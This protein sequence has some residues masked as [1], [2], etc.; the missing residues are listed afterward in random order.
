MSDDTLPLI[1]IVPEPLPELGEL[2]AAGAP[3][4]VI[5]LERRRDDIEL[6]RRR[7]E[8]ERRKAY[9]QERRDVAM[10]IAQLSELVRG[11]AG[12]LDRLEL[13]LAGVRA[14]LHLTRGEVRVLR[15]EVAGFRGASD[16]LADRI[17]ALEGLVEA[18]RNIDDRLT[19][20]EAKLEEENRGTTPAP[21][22]PDAD[23]TG[24][25]DGAAP[26]T[27]PPSGPPPTRQ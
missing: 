24:S 19:R 25:A 4:W 16:N 13:G 26:E 21:A 2:E 27:E 18:V 7:C 23:S 12:R 6:E 14:D 15:D 17:G 9:D 10:I 11:F 8:T 1:S 20:L 22:T 3:A 5:V